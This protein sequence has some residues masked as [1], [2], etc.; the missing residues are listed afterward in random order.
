M[1]AVGFTEFG[2]P[3]VL[4][5]LELPAP[6]AGPG[7]VRIRVHAATVNAVDALQR[8]GVA[9]SPDAQPPFVPGM[10]AAGVVDQIGTGTN[11]DLRVGDRVMA[12]V[13]S[14]GSHG[15][16]AEQ[17]VVP[18][19]SVVRAPD[20]TTDVQ[21]ATL[22]MN[23]LTARLA[24]DTLRLEPG[25]TVAITGAAGAV[26]GY[27]VQLAKADGLRVV[28]DASEQD[29]ALIKEL[30]ADVVLRR[31]AEYPGRV[32]AEVPEGVDGL[33]DTASL[34]ALTAH[35]VRDGGRVVTLLGYDG[36]GERD[37]TYEPIVVFRY[38]REH[39]RLDRL[40]QQ[41]EDGLITLRVAKSFPAEQ[42]TEAH[43]LLAAGGVRGR[44][45]LTF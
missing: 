24:L 2:G 10:E 45:V 32:R 20:A 42:A 14:N 13:L 35:A 31:G 30:G 3:E 44:L 43:R 40:R 41:A 8:S 11:T 38:A 17:V 4:Q 12:I 36:P 21:A 6:D 26:G 19:E 23:G 39:A 15:A 7:E 34:G 22:P 37:I 28:A 25:Q 9:R 27:A 16:Y 5:V 18:V 33:V 29:E 1:K